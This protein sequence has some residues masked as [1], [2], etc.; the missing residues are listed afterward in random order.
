M[1]Y[2]RRLVIWQA[3]ALSSNHTAPGRAPGGTGSRRAW[4]E[5]STRQHCARWPPDSPPHAQVH[6]RGSPRAGGDRT[7]AYHADPSARQPAPGSARLTF[8]VL[9]ERVKR[10]RRFAVVGAHDDDPGFLWARHG[11][12]PGFLWARTWLPGPRALSG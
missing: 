5:P 8:V 7:P 9:D 1:V 2:P 11:D 3:S 12:D 10:K 6:R 4:T